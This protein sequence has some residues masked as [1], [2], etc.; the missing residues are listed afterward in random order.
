MS[1]TRYRGKRLAVRFLTYDLEW[2]PHTFEER[3]VGVFD[4]KRYRSYP[5]TLEFLRNELTKKNRGKIFFAHA[6][7]LADAQFILKEFIKRQNPGYKL[8]A[9]FSGSSAVI[10]RISN[11]RNSWTFCDSLWLLKAGLS[12]IGRSLGLE[13]GGAD[14]FCSNFPNCSHPLKKDGGPSCIFYSPIPILRDYNALDCRILYTAIM[15]LQDELLA[16]G[17][18]LM[19]TIASSAL[20]LFRCAF[21]ERDIDTDHRLNEKMRESYIASRVEVIQA[22]CGEADY[23]DINSSFPFSMTEKLPAAFLGESKT[24]DEHRP[25]DIIKATVTIPKMHIPPIPVRIQ[26]KGYR[27][28]FFP[29]GTFTRWMTTPDVRMVLNSGGTIERIHK[30]YRFDEFHEMGNYV[31]AVYEMR[32]RT[33]DPFSRIVYKLLMNSLYGK[34][35]ESSDK[36]KVLINPKRKPKN[37]TPGLIKGVWFVDEVVNVAHAHVPIAAHITANSRGLIT[38]Y[39]QESD[40][41]YYC[42]TDSIVTT[43]SFETGDKLGELKH[44]KH[45]ESGTFLAP[46][47][48]RLFPGPEIR[49]KGFPKLS[50]DEFSRLKEGGS[51]EVERMIRIREN[52]RLGIT[53]PREEKT[54]KR[55]LSHLPQDRLR[56]LGVPERLALRPKRAPEKGG[57]TRAWDV[58]ELEE[59]S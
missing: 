12:K 42:D 38:E 35:G 57:S 25:T 55:T 54:R 1:L 52:L 40:N 27:R 29:T 46:K 58:G 31:Q 56:E 5:T 48:Y 36:Q 30:V 59:D 51:V 34:F 37:A 14:Y 15:R 41:A 21:L 44:E 24:W 9:T 26:T 49:A 7:G 3:L 23:Y 28:V 2:Y 53:Q 39:L 6:G 16:L 10:I 4:G 33:D 19:P 47:L 45:I 22:E 18:L 13:K 32:R 20:M 43:S 50:D 8:T 11:G 17:G